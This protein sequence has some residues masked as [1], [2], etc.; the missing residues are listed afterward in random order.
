MMPGILFLEPFACL[1]TIAVITVMISSAAHHVFHC[2][3]ISPAEPV[4]ICFALV[5]REMGT[6]ILFA[7][8]D[9]GATM[10]V[11]VFPRPFDTILEPLSP[12]LIE[13]IGRCIPRAIRSTHS[14]VVCA[15]QVRHANV[16]SATETLAIRTPHA[17][18]NIFRS[19]VFF[20]V[21][22]VGTAV[23]AKVLLCSLDTIVKPAALYFIPSP[24]C[25]APVIAILAEGGGLRSRR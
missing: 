17:P 20:S 8:F 22:N 1:T 4:A 14:P 13:F 11:E 16:V 15:D 23:V 21:V 7:V 24:G 19:N 12:K 10:V 18:W 3:S 2:N 25:L 9:I 6:A 5:G